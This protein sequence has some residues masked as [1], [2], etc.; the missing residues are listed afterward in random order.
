LSVHFELVELPKKNDVILIA[1]HAPGAAVREKYLTDKNVSAFL[2]VAQDISGKARRTAI[3]IALGIGIR[4]SRM[5]DT[6]FR[7]EAIG[8]IFGEQAVLCG[9]LAMLTK[10]GFEV[11]IEKGHNPEHA[12]LEVAYQ[13]DLIATLIRK[14]GIE[15]M[16]DKISLAARFG[17]I[18][19]GPKI[20]DDSVKTRMSKLYDSIA[21]GKFARRFSRIDRKGL[22]DLKKRLKKL[23]HPQLE[24]A[25]KKFAK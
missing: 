18:E 6:T 17:S 7:D 2:A 14:H 1:P 16:L 21:S 3:E 22:S 4:R 13:L 9:G 5:V 12:F 24:N 8:D 19:S 11:L 20:I 25:A 23:S 10:S 15:G